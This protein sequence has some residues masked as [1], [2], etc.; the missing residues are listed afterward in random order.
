MK[1]KYLMV[2]ILAYVVGGTKPR[3][4]RRSLSDLEKPRPLLK[5]GSLSKFFPFFL[6]ISALRYCPPTIFDVIDLLWSTVE[7]TV[8]DLRRKSLIK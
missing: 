2:E 7:S 4:L 3:R 6:T 1:E 8:E 5:R